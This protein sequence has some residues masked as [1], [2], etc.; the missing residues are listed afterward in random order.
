MTNGTVEAFIERFEEMRSN[1]EEEAPRPAR[2][3]YAP[4]TKQVYPGVQLSKTRIAGQKASTAR[5]ASGQDRGN[6]KFDGVVLPAP[7]SKTRTSGRQV[8]VGVVI[9]TVNKSKIRPSNGSG[10]RKAQSDAEDETGA[11]EEEGRERRC[12]SR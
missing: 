11:E 2:R 1:D 4:R 3:S 9:P 5:K 12:S 7:P 6:L 10:K 8:L